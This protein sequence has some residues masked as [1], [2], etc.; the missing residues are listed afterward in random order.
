MSTRIQ[1]PPDTQRHARTPGGPVSSPREASADTAAET[2][3]SHPPE[4]LS[5]PAATDRPPT[6]GSLPVGARLVLRCRKDWRDAAVSFVE[7]GRV[8][9]S[10]NSPT[11]HSYR[12]RRPVDSPLFL[13]GHVPVLGEGT[14]LCWRAGRARY[15]ARW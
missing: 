10:V 11:G 14:P 15:D 2:S 8:V 1:G 5:G 13:D 12:V 6:L 4:H 7:P 9:L 3:A